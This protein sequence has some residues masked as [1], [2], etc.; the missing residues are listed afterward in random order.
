MEEQKIEKKEVKI[1]SKEDAIKILEN[2]H[3]TIYSRMKG[4]GLGLIEKIMGESDEALEANKTLYTSYVSS[5]ANDVSK[6]I[7]KALEFLK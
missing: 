1:E 6:T 7:K 2:L 5:V 4:K 3:I